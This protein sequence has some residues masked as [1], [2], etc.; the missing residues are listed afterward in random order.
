MGDINRSKGIAVVNYKPQ[1]FTQKMK[2]VNN[3]IIY[4]R[5][6]QQKLADKWWSQVWFTRHHCW[7]VSSWTKRTPTGEA[8][9][10]ISLN[11]C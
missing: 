10:T 6:H 4:P 5:K 9:V 2:A 8:R 1:D 11:M 7:L 3:D